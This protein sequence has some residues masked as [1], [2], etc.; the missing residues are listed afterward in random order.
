MFIISILTKP[1]NT[2]CTVCKNCGPLG[3]IP[4]YDSM[5]S[6]LAT[7][8]TFFQML[9]HDKFKLYGMKIFNVFFPFGCHGNPSSH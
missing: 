6:I 8:F 2:E 7:L 5:Y 1:I 9:L 3:E 4:N